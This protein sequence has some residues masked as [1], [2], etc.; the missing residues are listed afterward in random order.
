MDK[1]EF[2]ERLLKLRREKGLFQK[3]LGDLLGVS[4]KAISKWENG[5]AMPKTE[6]MLKLAELLGI[7]GNELL[8]IYS[9]PE[10]DES[11]TKELDRLKSENLALQ[12]KIDA[13]AKNKKRWLVT[14][15]IIFAVALSVIALAFCISHIKGNEKYDL[16]DAGRTDTKIVFNSSEYLPCGENE[17]RLLSFNKDS[18]YA[19]SEKSAKYIACDGSETGVTVEGSA[20]Y[21]IV[22]LRTKQ[23]D[24]Y[25]IDKELSVAVTP[26]AI[27]SAMLNYGS[28]SNN[29]NYIATGFIKSYSSTVKDESA[30]IKLFCDYYNNLNTPADKKISEIYLGN[31]GKVVTLNYKGN[32]LPA[33]KVGEFFEN[34]NKEL[35][36]YNYADGM[37]YPA[38]EELNT[39]VSR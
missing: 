27:S 38:G 28:I 21:K 29:G 14:V 16:A 31:N 26:S 13:Q 10:P 9:A 24:F 32:F 33:L 39:F 12:E 7:D 6:T 19:G 22:R 1:N 35:Y 4:N 2:S 30:Q 3:D 36:F 15:F 20:E 37:A 8:G 23:G 5:E 11:F 25:Y 17:N 34:N 18:F